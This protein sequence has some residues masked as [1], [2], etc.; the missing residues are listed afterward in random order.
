MSDVYQPA[1]TVLSATTGSATADAGPKVK[2]L[3][4]AG[5][6]TVAEL[7]AASGMNALISGSTTLPAGTPTYSVGDLIANSATANLV[8]P[9]TLAMGRGS[10]GV[11]AS[12]MIRRLRLRKTGTSITSA[13]FRVHLYRTA[14][15]TC[16][17]GDDG[18]FSTDQ[19]ANYV[20]RIDVTVDQAFTDGASGNGV[21][22]VG[23]EINFTSQNYYALIE[24]RA[25]YTRVAAEV[26]TV[27]LEVL[28]N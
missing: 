1:G 12:G 24:A 10:S 8:V 22:S 21:P 26:F 19:A 16:A 28:Q 3:K 14:T 5:D 25:A 2:T 11:S 4:D 17:N 23:S 6:G 9:I 15:I 18:V 20:G 7:V 27:E 13:S